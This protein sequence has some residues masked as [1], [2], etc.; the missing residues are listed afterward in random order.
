MGERK[1]IQ[2]RKEEIK[3][4]LF[5][6]D[7]ILHIENSEDS[8]RKQGARAKQWIQKSCNFKLECTY[9]ASLTTTVDPKKV[10]IT[11]L[12]NFAYLDYKLK[13]ERFIRSEEKPAYGL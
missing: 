5:A 11:S 9:G 10:F 1:G 3:M 6:D 12:I 4:L 8:I 13:G 7:M 2:I